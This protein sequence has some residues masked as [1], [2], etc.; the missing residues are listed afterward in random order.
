MENKMK[1]Y[2]VWVGGSEVNSSL[3]SKKQATEIASE[4]WTNGYEDVE[5][6]KVSLFSLIKK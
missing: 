5:I 3:L 2:T 4:W 1:R 6:E